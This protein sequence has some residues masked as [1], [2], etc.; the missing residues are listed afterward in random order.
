MGWLSALAGGLAGAS[1]GVGGILDFRQQQ[2]ENDLATRRHNQYDENLGLDKRRLDIME[3]NNALQKALQLQQFQDLAYQRRTQQGDS[4]LDSISPTERIDPAVVPQLRQS[5]VAGRLEV[6]RPTLDMGGKAAPMPGMVLTDLEGNAVQGAAQSAPSAQFGEFVTRRMTPEE[7]T[8][9]KTLADSKAA[10]ATFADK[11][12]GA[13]TDVDRALALEEYAVLSGNPNARQLAGLVNAGEGRQPTLQE[14]YADALRI[15][16]TREAGILKQAINAGDN[17]PQA[18]Q[19]TSIVTSTDGIWR[20][21][22]DGRATPVVGPDGKPLTPRPTTASRGPQMSV[23]EKK[24]VDAADTM[25]AWVNKIE[26][27]G[28][29]KKWP[30]IGPMAGTVGAGLAGWFGPDAPLSG[31]EDGVKLRAMFDNARGAFSA[32]RAGLTLTPNEMKMLDAT[33][34]ALGGAEN[35]QTAMEKMKTTRDYFLLQAK[36][37]R[38]RYAPKADGSA[39]EVQGT[40]P[41]DDEA[42]ALQMEFLRRLGGGN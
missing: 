6:D 38:D 16:D 4:F 24:M 29:E 42:A 32:I 5:G 30:G 31:G 7:A 8:K 3:Q 10:Y 15:G 9:A 39:P 36:V 14:R 1:K 11:L 2:F 19:S 35:P 28:T 23:S 20:V 34:S 37:T 26:T 18:P 22:Q 40:T 27:F 33:I 13:K 17:P 41:E 12:G 21:G 25:D